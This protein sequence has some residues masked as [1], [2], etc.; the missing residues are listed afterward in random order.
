[1]KASDFTYHRPSSAQELA[2]LLA[3]LENAKVLAG[4]QSLMPMMNLRLL[5]PEHL[6]DI[7]KIPGLAGIRRDGDVI[8]IGAMTRQVDVLESE[9]I[10][11][12]LP[13]LKAALEHVGHVQ[14]RSRGTFGGSCCHLDPAA[15]QPALCRLLDAEFRVNGARG[16][17]VVQAADWFQGMLES[18]LAE[19]EFLEAIRIKPWTG[20]YGYGFEEYARRHG[21]FA[22]AGAAAML[23]V[24]ETQSITRAALM[25]FGVEA[26]PARLANAEAALVGTKLPDLDVAIVTSAARGLEAMS[27]VHVSADYRSHLGSVMIKRALLKATQH[28]TGSST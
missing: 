24:D 7:N 19:D 16:I 22:I 12:D 28:L 18:A 25:I 17:R 3:S 27:D 15:E 26:S 20:S 23:A 2:G 8:E 13:V 10:A 1:M 6:I 21:D 5:A 9:I 14:T 11:K 4:G